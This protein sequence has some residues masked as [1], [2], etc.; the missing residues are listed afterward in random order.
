[1]R[2]TVEELSIIICG[3]GGQG[4]VLMSE[5]L[6][7][8][9]VREKLSISGSEVLGMAQRGG[10]VVS[11]I[12]IGSEFHAPLVPE[13]R[14]DIMVV[15]EPSEALR[16]IKYLSGS[17]LVILNTRRIIPFTVFIEKSTYPELE[18]VIKKLNEVADNVIAIDASQIAEESGSLLSTN[19]AMLGALFGIGRI[20][21][22]VET[23]K[24]VIRKKLPARTMV[25]NIKAFDLG[26]A[27][28][29]RLLES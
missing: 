1:M 23:M 5:L 6:G 9:V 22:D 16:N 20:P 27:T 18:I 12:R 3:V 25:A 10:S 8:A 21:V 13:G 11:N 2:A 28:V 15:L 14:C 7:H 24:A 26:Y 4:V 29:N 17:S 19:I